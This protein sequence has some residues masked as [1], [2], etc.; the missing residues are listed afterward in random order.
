MTGVEVKVILVPEQIT[1]PGLAETLMLA[2]TYGV[3]VMLSELEVAGLPVT[4][5]A[6]DVKTQVMTSPLARVLDEY[7]VL[8]VP[9][10][11]PPTFH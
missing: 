10:F 8:F 3:T 4:Q 5:V 11:V 9:T 6:F 7:A 2:V 1:E